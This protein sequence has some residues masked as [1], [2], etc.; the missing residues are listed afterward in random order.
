MSPY[1][2][3][4]RFGHI[5]GAVNTKALFNTW[6][7][8]LGVKWGNCRH[9]Q[10]E[11]YCKNLLVRPWATAQDAGPDALLFYIASK[12]AGCFKVL[13]VRGGGGATLGLTREFLQYLCPSS[14][15]LRMR[16]FYHGIKY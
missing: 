4:G 2:T 16:R 12:S 3:H 15:C 9:V 11:I 7:H 5:P 8:N 10:Q 13:L 14:Q 1:D 6:Y